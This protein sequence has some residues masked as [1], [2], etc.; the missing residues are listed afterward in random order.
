[1]NNDR[2]MLK[3]NGFDVSGVF[4]FR[5]HVPIVQTGNSYECR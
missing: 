2:R 5:P 3:M 1:M 4:Y